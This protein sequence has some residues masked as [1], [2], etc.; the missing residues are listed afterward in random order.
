LK[1][2]KNEMNKQQQQQQQPTT[3]IKEDW[4][5]LLD[6]LDDMDIK[7]NP[8]V[9]PVS[10][11]KSNKCVPKKLSPAEK[12][13]RRIDLFEQTGNLDSNEINMILG[14]NGR[15]NF[16]DSGYF[17]KFYEFWITKQGYYPIDIFRGLDQNARESIQNRS[18]K[19]ISFSLNGVNYIIEISRTHFKTGGFKFIK[20]EDKRTYTNTKSHTLDSVDSHLQG[21]YQAGAL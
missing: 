15:I 21:M 14:E 19:Q 4:E 1:Q 12:N 16:G 6:N 9:T 17:R 20:I 3:D 5:L 11:T 7:T 8:E 18:T 13:S 10:T 2:K